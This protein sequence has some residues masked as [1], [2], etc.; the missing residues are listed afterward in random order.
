MMVNDLKY[1]L[2]VEGDGEG[3]II[4]GFGGRNVGAMTAIKGIMAGLKP[5]QPG[6]ALKHRCLDVVAFAGGFYLPPP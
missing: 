3:A 5:H 6:C 2:R 1:P 4:D